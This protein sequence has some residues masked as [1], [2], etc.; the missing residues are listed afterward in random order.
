MRLNRIT[1]T[2]HPAG[3]R[4]DLTWV[5][6]DPDRYPGVRVVRREGTYPTSPQKHLFDLDLSF[7]SELNNPTP[8]PALQQEFLRNQVAL[9]DQA[10]IRTFNLI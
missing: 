1:A 10:A 9:S 8:S 6:P 2:P 5:N 7:Q 4:I 3:N